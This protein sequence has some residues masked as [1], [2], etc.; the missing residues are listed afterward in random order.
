MTQ[1]V[2]PDQAFQLARFVLY[3]IRVQ[4]QQLP[5][6]GHPETPESLSVAIEVW[7]NNPDLQ[8]STPTTLAPTLY[9]KN[10]RW[11][12]MDWKERYTKKLHWWQRH[13]R[14]HS[15]DRLSM[16]WWNEETR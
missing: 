15:W 4:D 16:L 1:P 14:R 12:P 11:S 7:L 3:R 5:Y 9:E 2:T 10:V 13:R 8:T 6:G